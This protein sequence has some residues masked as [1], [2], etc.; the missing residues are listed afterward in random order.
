MNNL[1]ILLFS[2]TIF[3]AS[4]C[5]NKLDVEEK[6][7]NLIRRMIEQVDAEGA[8]AYDEFVASDAIWHSP[9]G[10]VEAKA[11][12]TNE[13]HTIEDV[14][15]EGDKVVARFTLRATNTGEYMS[16]SPTS[17]EVT[18][19]VLA[20]YRIMDSKIVEGWFLFDALGLLEQIKSDAYTY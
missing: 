11:A 7:K 15:A 5:T 20:I 4:A 3:I 10:Y 9:V 16:I 14:V 18:F 19:T 17:R 6:N 12:F 8:S 1:L 13:K 2:V